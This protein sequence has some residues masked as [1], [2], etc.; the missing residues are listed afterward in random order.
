MLAKL[1]LKNDSSKGVGAAKPSVDAAEEGEGG[2]GECGEV[3]LFEGGVGCS[4]PQLF[5]T[6]ALSCS[7]SFL[8]RKEKAMKK[9][10]NCQ[11]RGNV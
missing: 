11:S 3:S 5:L 2:A 10:K 6:H 4:C 9:V 1:S 7:L 8:N